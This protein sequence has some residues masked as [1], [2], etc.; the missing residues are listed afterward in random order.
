LKHKRQ[1]HIPVC[2][3]QAWVDPATP[4]NYEPYIWLFSKTGNNLRKRSPKN[5]FVEKDMY[6][7]IADDGSRDLRI[8]TNLAKLEGE[9]SEIRREKLE[10]LLPLDFKDRLILMMFLAA[11]YARTKSYEAHWKEQW[12]KVLDLGKK[13]HN[14]VENATQAERDRMAS[15]SHGPPDENSQS[16]TLEDVEGFSE[17]P[18]QSSIDS[19]MIGLPPM[20]M[21][22]P[23]VIIHTEEPNRFITSDTPCIWF[24]NRAFETPYEFGVGGLISPTLEITLPISPYLMLYLGRGLIV[25]G[26]YTPIHDTDL[27]DNF[28]KRTVMWSRDNCVTNSEEIRPTWLPSRPA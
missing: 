18:I 5:S 28:N 4:T 21:D 22:I 3:S 23:S 26:L 9:F 12:Q 2:Y 19:I 11:M 10:K 6:T 20:I 25:D 14:W 1:H 24:D 15:I 16:F 27:I 17:K 8:E 13:M 7:V